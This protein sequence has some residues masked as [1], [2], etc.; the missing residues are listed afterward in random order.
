MLILLNVE[1]FLRIF[2]FFFEIFWLY[3]LLWKYSIFY[4]DFP[5]SPANHPIAAVIRRHGA[6]GLA[7]GG[8]DLQELLQHGAGHLLPCH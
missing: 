3:F 8:Q 4:P 1:I 6:G 7:A 5:S 2:S